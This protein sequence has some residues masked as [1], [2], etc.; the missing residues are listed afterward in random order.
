MMKRNTKCSSTFTQAHHKPDAT[1]KS[2][3]SLLRNHGIRSRSHSPIQ[4]QAV[5]TTGPTTENPDPRS[6]QLEPKGI[7]GMT[8]NQMM[9]I[10]HNDGTPCRS[11]SDK[12]NMLRG[13]KAY[14]KN[15]EEHTRSC[16]PR[17][18]YGQMIMKQD[19]EEVERW[20]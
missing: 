18:Q 11:Y 5:V 9:A 6:H 8:I 19:G 20:K 17:S 4:G 1:L 3:K 10:V 2:F 12:S 15:L 14:M 7:S 16:D 13:W